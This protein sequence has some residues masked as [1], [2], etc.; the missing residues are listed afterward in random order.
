MNDI[1][2]IKEGDVVYIQHRII[3]GHGI[4]IQFKIKGNLFTRVSMLKNVND[5]HKNQLLWWK[6]ETESYCDEKQSKE[7]EGIIKAFAFPESFK[8]QFQITEK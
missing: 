8:Q 2:N 3:D 4:S 5:F 6:T 7:L 1:E